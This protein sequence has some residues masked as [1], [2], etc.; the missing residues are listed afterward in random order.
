M[1]SV[2]DP[3]RTMQVCRW[4]V[5]TLWLLWGPSCAGQLADLKFERSPSTVVSSL[6]KPV[7]M[8]CDLK[9]TGAE[10]VDPPDVVW[11]RD[12]V[13]LLY[14]DTNQVQVPTGRNSWTVTSTLRIEKVQLSDMG[15]YR[16][17]VL[18]GNNRT[19]SEEGSI[20]LEGLPHFSMEPRHMSVVANVSLSLSCVAHGP[21]EPVRVIW[22]Q[23]GAPLNK[24]TDPVALSP[25]KLNLTGLN[26]SSTFSCEAHNHK[27]V[28]TSG[29]GTVTVLPSP[30]QNLRVVEIN[31]TALRLS[32][33]PGF[34]GEYPI[35]H[36]FVQAK[37]GGSSPDKMIHNQSVSVPPAV[38]LIGDLEPHSR[39]AVRV[40]CLT[41]QGPSDW[42]PW[43]ELRTEEGVPENPPVNVTAKP[44]GTEVLVMWA[45]PPGKLN[46]ELQG[47]M[48][49]YST[50]GTPQLVADAGLDTE[51][52]INLSVPLSNVSFRVCAYTGAGQG[53]WTPTQTLVLISPET[54]K[55]QGSSTPLAFSWHWWY[56]VMAIAGAVALAV[57][58]AVYVAKLRRKETRFGEAFEPMME[59][60]E[61]VVRYRARRSYS[62]RTTEATL[63]SL[64]ISDELKQKLQDVMVDRHKLTLGKTLG[65]G[66]FGSVMEGLLTQEEFVLKVAVK[67]MKIAICT[68]SE[69]EDFLREAACMKEFD[70]PN[71]MRLLGVCLQTVESE[72]YPSPVV[73]LP[74]MKHGDLHSYLLYS[75]LGDSPVFLPS[76][77]LVK[78]MTDIARGMEYLSSKNFIHRDLAARNCMLDENM[79]VCVADFG[80]SKKIYNGDYYRQGRIS[81]MPVK[82]IAIESLADRV[83]T[84]KSDVWS[85]GVTM[86]EIATR[87]QTPYPGVENSE[88]YDYLRQGNRLKQPPDC[89]DSIYS[90]MFSCWL[91]SP[92][93]RPSFE[94]LCYELEKAL[95]DLPDAQDPDEILYVNMDESPMDLGAV[96]GRDPI[97]GSSPLFLKG[98]ESV[99]TAE[100]HQP[101]RYV[102]CPQHET[103]RTLCESLES[104]DMPVSSSTATLPLQPSRHDTPN[105]TPTSELLEDLD[106]SGKMPWQ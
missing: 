1:E 31:Q 12:G 82:W 38:H 35:I 49:E 77:M 54:G 91:L 69:M 5:L 84:A 6:G 18:S 10:E 47:Y 88:I 96:G 41:N 98:L 70:H 46:G 67:T 68:R 51:L 39:Y 62:R 86:W 20:Q 2:R 89:L 63:N 55:F 43:A 92:K 57:L 4:T 90:L 13:P 97:R 42:T 66:E 9:G 26:R 65:E 14:A 61:L 106:G 94:T 73:I 72:G 105:R 40:A 48:V 36:C 101:N 104:L 34:G 45:E 7:S 95:E 29:S 3:S 53:P 102:L 33:Q 78:F 60:G 30:P 50:P 64:G 19:L 24:L 87:G 44:N 100:V 21:P 23:D 56:V 74:Y 52:S 58:L 25:S 93:D 85:F 8:R 17:A 15:S 81:K 28:A 11:L 16:C 59:R 27:G 71:V 99:T 83:Y 37:T 22:L 75:R 32:W 79:N 103:N 80:L 76:Q